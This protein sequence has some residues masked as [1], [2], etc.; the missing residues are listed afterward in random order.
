[1]RKDKALLVFLV[2]SILAML[3]LHYCV[4]DGI[5]HSELPWWA[6]AVFWHW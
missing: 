1:M 3:V 2:V 5:L 4:V 6:K